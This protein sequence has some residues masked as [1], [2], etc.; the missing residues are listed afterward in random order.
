M[1]YAKRVHE[2]I[3]AGNVFANTSL[4]VGY[5]AKGDMSEARRL[6]DSSPQKNFVMWT[7]IISGCVK[8]RQ[9]EDAFVLFREY[10]AQEA[11]IPDSVI[12]V[13]LLGAFPIQTS[14]NSGKQIHAYIFRTR[15][16]MMRKQI[17]L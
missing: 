3:A 13:S 14:V 4:I 1:G 11:T 2:T 12:L 5:S 6:F 17:V 10:A 9:C 15:I 7:A 16:T 8:L